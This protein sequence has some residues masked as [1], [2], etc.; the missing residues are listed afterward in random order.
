MR[1]REENTK[2]MFVAVQT[3]LDENQDKIQ[4]TPAQAQAKTEFDAAV[5]EIDRFDKLNLTVTAGSQE[6]KKS[7][8][9]GLVQSLLLSPR[10]CRFMQQ[11]KTARTC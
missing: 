1:K 11:Q 8:K 6:E 9:T 10:R 2:T 4:Q 5:S 7:A 3:K